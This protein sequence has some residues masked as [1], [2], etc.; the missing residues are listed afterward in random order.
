MSDKYN[1]WTHFE[2]WQANLWLTNDEGVWN[3][4]LTIHETGRGVGAE[5]IEATLEAMV[6]QTY[7]S[8]LSDITTAWLA[9]VNFQEIADGFN[10]GTDYE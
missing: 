7:S 6:G 1:G 4:I 2:T 10:E 8:L 3:D 5:D 9:C